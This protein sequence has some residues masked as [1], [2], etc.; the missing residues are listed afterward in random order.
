MKDSNGKPFSKRI[1]IHLLL[2]ELAHATNSSIG[3]TVK[4]YTTLKKLT[5]KAFK[6]GYISSKK[7]YVPTSYCSLDA[8]SINYTTL[9]Q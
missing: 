3:H 2:H 8:D 5:Y 9:K 6:K 4:F 7:I 1:L